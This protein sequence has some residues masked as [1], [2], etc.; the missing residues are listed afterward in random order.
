MKQRKKAA[1]ITLGCKVN[2]AETEGM[3]L[4][5]QKADYEIVEASEH[6]DVYV[7]NTCT[8]TGMGDK[9]SRQ[10][11]RRAHT[12]N[13]DAIIAVVG[14]FAQVSPEET[15]KIEGVNLVLGNNMKHRIVELVENTQKDEKKQYV[16][17]RKTLMEY[18]ELPVEAYEGHTRAFLK[19]QDGCDQFCSYCII[20]YARGPVRSRDANDVIKEAKSFALNGFKEIVLTGIH[21]TSYN[22]IKNNES[23][24]GLI[25]AV[26]DIEG[27]ERIRLGSLEPMFITHEF[28]EEIS[29]LPKLCPHFH[30][31]LQSG[32]AETLKRMNRK[33]TPEYY[34]EIVELMREKIP[35]VTFTTDVMVGFPGETDEE[36]YKSYEFCK[37]IGFLW[38]HVFK[39][40]PRK[41][42]AAAKFPDQVQPDIKE[43]RSKQLIELANQMRNKVF[44]QF[45]GRQTD[46]I[47][48]KHIEGSP[49]DM[50]GLTSNYIPVAVNVENINPG[51]IISVHL[52][53][54]EGER[55]RGAVSNITV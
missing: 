2:I 4:L 10:M 22:D 55:M 15:S 54:I 43:R 30:L 51:E 25:R 28:I 46:I 50:E 35:D 42:T 13:P 9:K 40:S 18:E 27:I 45:L 29:V 37:E 20:P 17:E 33:Y 7:I 1:F 23:L 47:L 14:C 48:E 38:I 36:F 5:F 34:R 16:N 41:G 11:I 19:V 49:G 26:H 21:L 53:T 3:K 32:C 8:V 12:L 44:Q 39:Y 31:S 24:P 52:E 6:A